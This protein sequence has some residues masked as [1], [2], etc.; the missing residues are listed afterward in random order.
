MTRFQVMHDIWHMYSSAGA[1]QSRPQAREVLAVNGSES[2]PPRGAA[3]ALDREPS[4][5]P[6]GSA[7]SA[8]RQPPA[9]R[10]PPPP[11][12]A[13]PLLRGLSP[14]EQEFYR[15]T[16][17]ARVALTFFQVVT[18]LLLYVYKVFAGLFAVQHPYLH[19]SSFTDLISVLC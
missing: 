5:R 18:C 6:K 3:A 16:I 2:E 19:L 10:P 17:Q 4:T 12:D 1:Q 14:S 8:G 13:E 7:S 11:N 15:Q 9:F